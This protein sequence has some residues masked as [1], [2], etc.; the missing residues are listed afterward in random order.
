MIMLALAGSERKL[1]AMTRRGTAA[2]SDL[3]SVRAERL[4]AQQ[5]ATE[6]FEN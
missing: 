1:E 5:K 4:L 6:L 3:Q 2:Q